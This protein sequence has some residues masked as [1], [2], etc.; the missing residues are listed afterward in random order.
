MIGAAALAGELPLA[1]RVLMVSG[2]AGFEIVQKAAVAGIAVVASVSAPSSLAADAAERLGLTLVGLPA[3]RRLQRLHRPRP[4]RRLMARTRPRRRDLWV[5]L[6][7]NGV[8]LTKPNHY[9]DMLKVVWEN[10]RALP[11]ASRILRKGVC[12]GCALGVA[13]LHDWTIDGVHLCTT[14]LNLLRVNTMGAMDHA[15]ARRR[16]RRCA[17]ARARE[18]R[19]LGR[20]A[21]PMVRRAGEPGFSRVSW[22]EAL[23]L[24]AGRIRAA[25]GDAVRPL[26]DRARDHERGLLH[27]R[28][29][30]ALPRL[31][32]HR[33]RRARLPRAVDRG[34]ADDGRRRRHHD[35]ATRT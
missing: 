11:Y 9:L 2:R 33:Q 25:G 29:G 34:A 12:D 14:R 13:G 7:P 23:D 35:L 10:R 3:R 1:D 16:R 18:L 8:G 31:Q 24:V 30:D 27:G 26:H 20:L 28:Q 5:S 17:A 21:H 4:D 19:D 15:P 32:Q 6:R 22:D